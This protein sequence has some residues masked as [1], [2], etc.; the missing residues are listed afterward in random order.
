M[1]MPATNSKNLEIQQRKQIF[2]RHISFR[3]AKIPKVEGWQVTG[4][5][6]RNEDMSIEELTQP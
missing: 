3:L 4:T 2:T 1:K 5:Y 6:D